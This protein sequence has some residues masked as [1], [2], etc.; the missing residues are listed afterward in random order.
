M[1]LEKDADAKSWS[2]YSEALKYFSRNRKT[3]P[4]KLFDSIILTQK[5]G[6]GEGYGLKSPNGQ[7]VCRLQGDGN[8]VVYAPGNVAIWQSYSYGKACPPFWLVCSANRDSILV[9]GYTFTPHSYVPIWTTIWQSTPYKVPGELDGFY[10]VGSPTSN[11]LAG[12]IA[13]QVT[14][15]DWGQLQV[16]L[17][18]R[19]KHPL[20]IWQ[21]ALPPGWWPP[22]ETTTIESTTTTLP[23][24]HPS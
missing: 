20:V 1:Q 2:L 7:Y 23:A 5:A 12:A 15:T 4:N 17:M 14:L 8:L 18:F 13:S 10:L 22:I 24:Y 21:S 19:D 16:K 6:L 11:A 3:Y 9:G